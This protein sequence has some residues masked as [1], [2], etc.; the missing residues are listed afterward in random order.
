MITPISLVRLALD[1][2]SAA[3]PSSSLRSTRFLRRTGIHFAGKRY[4]AAQ[5]T[6]RQSWF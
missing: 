4:V 6:A 1:A 5:S 2:F 3:T